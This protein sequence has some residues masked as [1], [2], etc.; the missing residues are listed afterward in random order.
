MRNPK[1]A[2]WADERATRAEQRAARAREHA[3]TAREL[4]AL[5]AKHG[6]N[7][8]VLLHVREA[9]LHE[10]AALR[11]IQAAALQRLHAEHLRSDR[12]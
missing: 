2:T 3:A 6:Q 4:A 7:E 9:A 1:L 12:H 5:D 8:H 11:H 10:S